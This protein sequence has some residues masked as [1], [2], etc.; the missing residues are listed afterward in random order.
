MV[1]PSDPEVIIVGSGAAGSALAAT[2]GRDGRRVTV[3][4]RD[5]KV[6][7]RWVGELLSTGG[8]GALRKLGLE[9]IMH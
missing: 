3:I 2:L 5:M 8:I 7:V 9:G 1:S 4:E 6:P